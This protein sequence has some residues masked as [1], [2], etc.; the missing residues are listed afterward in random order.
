MATRW[1]HS[2]PLVDGERAFRTHRRTILFLLLMGR[3]PSGLTAEEPLCSSCQVSQQKN[4]SVPLVDGERAFRSHSRRTIL[5]L[6]LMGRGPS[7]LTA[8]VPFC[9]SC[10]WGEDRQV[11]QQKNHSVPLVDGERAFRSHSRRTILFLLLK[12]RGPSALT[13]EEPFCSSCWWREGL[14]VS[15]QKNHSVPLVDGE[16][17]FSSHSRRTILFLLLMGREP[18]SLTAGEPFCSSC[19]WGEGLQVSQQKNHSVPLI[20]G[21]RTFRSHNRRTILFLLLMGRVPSGLTAEAEMPKQPQNYEKHVLKSL[22]K[23]SCVVCFVV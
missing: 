4:H 10:W 7:G 15:Q 13:A 14:Q 19:R 9:S 23:F 2:V 17:A 22:K 16:R 20:D 21:K 18:S 11:S 12:G 5:F 1:N 8:E 3:G 6:L